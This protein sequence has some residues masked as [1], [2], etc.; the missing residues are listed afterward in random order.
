MIMVETGSVAL[1][2]VWQES[3]PG[4]KFKREN[5]SLY[6][7]TDFR[8]MFKRIVNVDFM[9]FFFHRSHSPCYKKLYLIKNVFSE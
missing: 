1:W 3:L 4:A 9:F 8:I 7:R 5:S 2:W 6:F